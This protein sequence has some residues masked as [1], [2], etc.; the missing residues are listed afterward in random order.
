MFTTYLKKV[1]SV[2]LEEFG[3]TENEFKSQSK[4]QEFV[5]CRKAFYIVIKEAYDV[6]Y[7][8]MAKFIDKSVSA[9][10]KYITNQPDNKYYQ[11]CLSRIKEK[12][13]E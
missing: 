5:Y 11:S 7:E 13:K 1:L 3:V 4:K 2:C 12:S 8:V 9:V 10:A 6:K